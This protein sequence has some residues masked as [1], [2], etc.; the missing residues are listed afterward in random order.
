MIGDYLVVLAAISFD[1]AEMIEGFLELA[2]DGFIFGSWLPTTQQYEKATADYGLSFYHSFCTFFVSFVIFSKN[3]PHISATAVL[4]S[5]QPHPWLTSM[6][7]RRLIERFH[8]YMPIAA[9]P[10]PA[11]LNKALNDEAASAALFALWVG[12]FVT[13]FAFPKNSYS[14]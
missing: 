8:L 4:A 2:D 13:K 7:E 5:Q 3:F 6:R 11:E 9:P 10:S 1:L 14:S 12:T